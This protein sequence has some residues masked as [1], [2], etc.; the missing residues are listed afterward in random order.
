MK[1]FTMW[2]E[3]V[4]A[5]QYRPWNRTTIRMANPRSTSSSGMCLRRSGISDVLTKTGTF[6]DSDCD[7]PTGLALVYLTTGLQATIHDSQPLGRTRHHFAA[8]ASCC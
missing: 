4:A 3:L 1:R 5:D 8:M 7:V 2:I 6:P